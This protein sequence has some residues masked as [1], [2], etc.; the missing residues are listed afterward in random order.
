MTRY[1]VLGLLL[2]VAAAIYL[3]RRFRTGRKAHEDHVDIPLWEAEQ[4]HHVD[5]RPESTQ[6][7]DDTAPAV[8]SPPEW[9]PP[10]A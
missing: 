9:K 7:R 1:W 10:R 5:P 8:L 3:V 2:A 6:D 4:F